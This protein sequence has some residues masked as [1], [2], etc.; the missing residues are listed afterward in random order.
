[1]SAASRI[2]AV[3]PANMA[4]VV[5]PTT[6]VILGDSL[7]YIV[8]PVSIAEF[9]IV[10]TWGLST[11][12]W[13][14]FALSINRFIRL[15]T[16]SLAA[17]TYDHFGLRWPLVA[18]TALGAL[19]TLSYGFTKGAIAL[20]VA[21]ALWGLAYSHLRLAAQLTA[22]DIADSKAR[23]KL[24]GIFNSGQRA[25]SFAAV[26]GGA[27]LANAYDRDVT[28]TVL[29]AIGLI[30][31][32]IATRA[33]SLT[34]RLP[35][36]SAARSAS[37]ESG[38]W[39]ILTGT[40]NDVSRHLRRL[41]LSISFLRF[42]TAFAANG[43]AIATVTPYIE[44]ILEGD[45][46]LFGTGVNVVTL[47]GILVGIRWFANLALAVPFGHV[48]DVYGRRRT[49]GV[50]IAFMLASLAV[51]GLSPNLELVVLTLPVLFLSGA[52]LE[53]ALD[54]AMGES[55]PSETRGIGM[56]RYGTWLDLGAAIGPILGFLI[57]E[58]FGFSAGYLIA[59]AVVGVAVVFYMVASAPE[60]R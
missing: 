60:R 10:E 48:A 44:E 37:S 7:I 8:L 46:T 50:G 26:T 30:G 53:T 58:R 59:V 57:G 20:I 42:S 22:L 47:A 1:M 2:S 6:A 19:T 9:G 16:N 28:F 43:L 14:G 5:F 27:F 4:V 49:I 41:M 18:A 55:T 12:F 13:I 35:V 33:P 39:R 32:L 36:I 15:A 17:Q 31:V 24:F 45:A 52:L 54:A 3:V 21:R 40:T 51:A 56:A 29:A 34:P 23:G 11:A 38:V 25:G